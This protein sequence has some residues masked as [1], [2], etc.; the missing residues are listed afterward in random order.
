M[1]ELIFSFYLEE[2][3]K[4]ILNA[5][6]W[7]SQHVRV[8]RGWDMTDSEQSKGLNSWGLP[9]DGGGECLCGNRN[10]M[11]RNRLWI[12][13]SNIF[14]HN[15]TLTH[16]HTHTHTQSVYGITF[17][18]VSTYF[19]PLYAEFCLQQL[20]TATRSQLET[21]DLM[22]HHVNTATISSA[23]FSVPGTVSVWKL[24]FISINK[25]SNDDT[26][27]TEGLFFS[28]NLSPVIFHWKGNQYIKLKFVKHLQYIYYPEAQSNRPKL[29]DA[30]RELR[31]IIITLHASCVTPL[32]KH[33]QGSSCRT[34]EVD[35]H[36]GGNHPSSIVLPR[37]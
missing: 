3:K 14:S 20:C 1:V 10:L 21:E 13:E 37:I 12:I 15:N 36:S 17:H 8:K 31:Q 29:L 18:V 25:G 2:F 34:W 11:R 28:C 27:Q 16:T 6:F 26:A 22:F 19:S 4:K 33:S 30:L 5:Y 24:Q 9:E 32:F 35:I 7:F 23:Y